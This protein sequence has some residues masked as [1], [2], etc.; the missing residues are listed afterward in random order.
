MYACMYVC[1]YVCMYACACVRTYGREC[2]WVGVRARARA[3]VCTYVC[4][5]A[6]VPEKEILIVIECRLTFERNK[7]KQ[8]YGEFAST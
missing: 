7:A 6:R 1:M 2:V 8:K 4:L 5:Y 3:R